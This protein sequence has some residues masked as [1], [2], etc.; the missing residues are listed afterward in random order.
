MDFI[1]MSEAK[2]PYTCQSNYLKKKKLVGIKL[3][4]VC[5][6]PTALKRIKAVR[7]DFTCCFA[8][9]LVYRF[10][11]RHFKVFPFFFTLNRSTFKQTFENKVLLDKMDRAIITFQPAFIAL[12]GYR[13]R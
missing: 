3:V 1:F 4:K 6:H 2:F 8:I 9:K 12:V 13:S 11:L 5:F 7:N 10:G